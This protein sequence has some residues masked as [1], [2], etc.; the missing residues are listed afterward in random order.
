MTQR[1]VFVHTVGSLA[2]LFAQLA[3]EI[4]PPAVE[5][6]HVSD[7]VLLK[8]VLAEGGLTPFAYRRVAEHAIAAEQAG[9][10][11]VQ[12][13][14]SSISP[15]ADPA[16]ALVSIP[17]LKVD[18][19]MVERAVELGARIG[20]VATVRTT[21][22][23]T[24]AAVSARAAQVGKSVAVDPVLCEG[25][26]AALLA[27]DLAT[28]DRLVRAALSAVLARNDVVLLAQASMAR[29]AGQLPAAELAVPLLTSP[30]LALERARDVLAAL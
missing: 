12:L 24:T 27:G 28:H 2:A 23:P 8:V 13:T 18:A 5:V 14:C 3:A 25:A 9:A 22:A 6:W 26:Y 4:L 20:V 1:L 30:R 7:E 21:L 10:S 11:A 17:V 19:P 15:C 29:V 16:Q